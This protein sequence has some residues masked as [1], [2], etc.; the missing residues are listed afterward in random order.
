MLDSDGKPY[1]PG[2]CSTCYGAVTLSTKDHS[3][4]GITRNSHY[5][6]VAHCSKVLRPGA[7]RLGISGHVPDGVT[8]QWY[9][10]PDGSYALII[11]N[12]GSDA[13]MN[14]VTDKVSI[15]LRIVAK[16]IQ[17]VIWTE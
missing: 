6:N 15:K 13:L 1:R 10:N 17:S 5:Y 14:I 8:C 2:G 3:F 7:V 9:R 11:L 12:Q 16:S 4:K